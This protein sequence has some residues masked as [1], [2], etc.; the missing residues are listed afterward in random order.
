MCFSVAASF[1]ASAV[2]VPM[3]IYCVKKSV[4]LER[5]YWAFALLPLM[6]GIQQF[7][8]GLVWLAIEPDGGGVTRLAALGYMFFSHLFW[9]IWIPFACYVV[10]NSTIKRK[11]VFI[12]IFIGAVHGLLMYIPLWFREDWLTVE[13][14]RQSIDYKATLLYDEYIPRI[15]VRAF[16]ALIILVPL[17]VASDRYIRIFGVIIATS[18]AISTVLFGYAFISI[19]CYFAAVLSFYILIMMLQKTKTTEDES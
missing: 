5:P 18:V 16:Y 2:L 9:L 6:F 8:E 3:G 4:S 13:L 7:F 12:L 15:I 10:E 17:L 19:W 1:S 11:V 14:V